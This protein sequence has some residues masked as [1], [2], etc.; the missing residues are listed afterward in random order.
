MVKIRLA[1]M[2]AKKKPIY[3]IIAA[4]EDFK[5][6]GRFLEKLGLYDPNLEPAKVEVKED[7]LRHWIAQGARTTDTVRTLLKRNGVAL[8]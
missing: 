4:N 6:D 2:G 7:R 3:R 5:R 1:R 8:S